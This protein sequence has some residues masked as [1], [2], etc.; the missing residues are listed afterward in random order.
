VDSQPKFTKPLKKNKQK[1]LLKIFQEVENEVTLP[2]SFYY[3]GIKLIQKPNEDVT[4]KENYRA[5]SLMNI[6]AKI[7][8]K[9]LAN[10]IQQ[11]VKKI[12][13]HNQVGFILGIPGCFSVC[14]SI[15]VIQNINRSKDKNHMMF[16]IDAEKAFDKV[17]H[18]FMIKALTKLG[19]EGFFFKTIRAMYDK[20]RAN[21]IV[22]GE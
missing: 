15:N 2:N 5:I 12:M 11:H 18:P 8:N 20:P 10:R 19:V 21:I 13:H 22:N 6:D 3:T 17:Q 4:R 1:I 16:S 14:K 9:V 7:L